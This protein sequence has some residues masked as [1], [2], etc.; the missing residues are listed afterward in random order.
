MVNILS[1]E[2][3]TSLHEPGKNDVNLRLRFLRHKFPEDI[4][5]IVKQDDGLPK[6]GIPEEIRKQREH[7]EIYG[8][9]Y[10]GL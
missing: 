2:L 4:A 6:D 1:L 7:E 8:S 5:E 10:S 3:E 9:G